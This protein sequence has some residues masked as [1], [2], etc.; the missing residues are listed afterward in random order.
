MSYRLVTLTQ[1]SPSFIVQ[2]LK[3]LHRS[4][5]NRNYFQQL[6]EIIPSMPSNLLNLIIE[7]SYEDVLQLEEEEVVQALA[8]LQEENNNIGAPGSSRA[9]TSNKKLILL[10]K[11]EEDCSICLEEFKENQ[12]I[13]TLICCH[14]FHVDCIETWLYQKNVCPLCRNIPLP[15]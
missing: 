5:P 15:I 2:F 9:K 12:T 7:R 8:G 13:R 11:M 3:N 1:T 4:I 10:D 6:V 14:E